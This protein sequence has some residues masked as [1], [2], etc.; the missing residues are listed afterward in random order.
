MSFSVGEATSVEKLVE[1][2]KDG[3]LYIGQRQLSLSGL[4]ERAVEST[5]EEVRVEGEK[6][7]VDREL[8]LFASDLDGDESLVTG[9]NGR[10]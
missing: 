6:I 4:D 5:A 2:V 7:L 8:L 1:D 3:D 9:A 10:C